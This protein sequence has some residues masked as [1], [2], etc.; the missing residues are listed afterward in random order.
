MEVIT[1]RD[2]YCA[3][4]GE[5]EITQRY[6][7]AMLTG[8]IRRPVQVYIP[9][10]VRVTHKREKK[11]FPIVLKPRHIGPNTVSTAD[12]DFVSLHQKLILIPSKQLDRLWREA[13]VSVS[14]IYNFQANNQKTVRR[15]TVTKLNN[16]CINLI[17]KS[18]F[19]TNN[20][21]LAASNIRWRP[22]SFNYTYK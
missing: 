4:T 22:F 10:T 5:I 15:F 14:T 6:A 20:Y 7:Q 13:G 12:P 9:A 3:V 17:G 11:T 18:T 8:R 19:A 2:V 21:A 16:V 1:W